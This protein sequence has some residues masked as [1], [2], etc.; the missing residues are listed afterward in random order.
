MNLDTSK[1]GEVV[2]TLVDTERREILF[3]STTRPYI[4]EIHR[5]TV[6]ERL[7]KSFDTKTPKRS[8]INNSTFVIQI[9]LKDIGNPSSSGHNKKCIG[10]EKTKRLV[11]QRSSAKTVVGRIWTRVQTTKF[12][13]FI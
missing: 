2:L 1:G 4:K 8:N 7:S 12:V 10:T 3:P 13:S 6:V 5:N 11:W 9:T